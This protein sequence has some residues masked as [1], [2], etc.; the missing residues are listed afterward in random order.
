MQIDGPDKQHKHD[1]VGT[2]LMFCSIQYTSFQMS[3]W[4]DYVGWYWTEFARFELRS[5]NI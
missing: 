4:S 2:L 5:W 1:R 3:S